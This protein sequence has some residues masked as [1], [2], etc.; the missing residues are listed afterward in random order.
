MQIFMQIPRNIKIIEKS[1]T[2]SVFLFGPRQTGKTSLLK[3]QLPK[4]TLFYDLLDKT[5][6]LRLSANLSLLREQL[7]SLAVKD[8]IVVIDEIQKLPELLDEVHLLIEK[9]Q[10]R[11]IL[12]GSSARKLHQK[13]VNLL[14][15]RARSLRLHP[16]VYAEL[17]DECFD[18]TKCLNRGLIPSIYFSDQP[19]LDLSSYVGTYLDIEIASEAA[20]RD[21]PSF[22]R[23]LTVAALCNGQVINYSSVG[24]D[25][26]VNRKITREYFQILFDT[27]LAWEVPAWGESRKRK[28]IET[29][30]FY[31]F[32]TG[33][34]RSILDLPPTKE[35]S[36]DFGDFFEAYIC[37]ELR[38]YLDYHRPDI[39]LSYWR[40]TSNHEVDFILSNELGV[41]VKAKSVVSNKDLRG[42][43]ALEEEKILK[44]LIVVSLENHARKTAE[45]ILILPFKVFLK[46]L[47]NHELLDEAYDY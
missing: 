19:R 34:V 2:R 32:D 40:T 29:P 3:A 43:M 41:E 31:F 12:T 18:L 23:F 44:K 9:H 28:S 27:Q 8:Q 36:K 24:N 33:V 21:L 25:A 20:I 16:L 30:K 26:A 45:G 39:G 22:S 6:L 7:E 13:G 35:K 4:E 17:G 14:G 11:F 5:L 47:W 38:S 42:L 15:G 1:L 46:Q 37:H 10:L